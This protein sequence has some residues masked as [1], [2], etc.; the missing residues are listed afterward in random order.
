MAKKKKMPIKD[1]VRKK[2][3]G[4]RI[5][6]RHT[7]A[8]GESLSVIAKR[9]YDSADREKWMLIYEAKKKKR[10]ETIPR[11]SEWGRC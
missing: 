6:A 10:L 4:P 3:K 8:A 9:Y 5:V 7:V 1:G 2:P 11:W